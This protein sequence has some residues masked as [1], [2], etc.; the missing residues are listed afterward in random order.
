M[1]ADFYG[2]ALPHFDE[3][4]QQAYG[5][6]RP[7]AFAL[8]EMITRPAELAGLVLDTGL[9]AQIVDDVGNESGALALMSYVLE[10]LYLRAKARGDR[11]LTRQD[12]EDELKGVRGAINTLADQAYAALPFDEAVRQQTLQAVFRELIALTEEDGQLIPTRRRSTLLLAL[13]A[14]SNEAQLI[15]VFVDARLLVKDDVSVEVAHE[16]ILRHWEAL[17]TWITAVKG[18]L[19]LLRQYERDARTWADRGKDTP[20]PAHEALIYL[21][22]ALVNLDMTWAGLGEPLK[23]YTEP[24]AERLQRELE[25]PARDGGEPRTP[26]GHRRPVGGDW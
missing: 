10:T 7:S 9:A 11:Q 26:P 3:L 4:K 17:A 5:L 13:G 18:D 19:A 15:D 20:P 8:Y 23:S 21:Y 24:E 16:A 25:N 12:Y 2:A 1:R 22:K 6:T 14:D